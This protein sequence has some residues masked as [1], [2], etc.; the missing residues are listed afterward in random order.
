MSKISHD[1]MNNNIT[2]RLLDVIANLDL[3]NN[4][5][6]QDNEQTQNNE[7]TQDNVQRPSPSLSTSLSSNKAINIHFY[8][9]NNNRDNNTNSSDMCFG[10]SN[11][12]NHNYGELANNTLSSWYNTQYA[13][14]NT[15]K[16]NSRWGNS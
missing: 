6:T 10:N 12:F 5:Q 14:N 9:G 3:Q 2:D 7:Q 11:V 16:L 15:D 8:C 13:G 1:D 4:E